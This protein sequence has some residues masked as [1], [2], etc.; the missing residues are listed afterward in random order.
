M[1]SLALAL[2]IPFMTQAAN[3]TAQKI[4]VDGFD[5]L[6]LTDAAHKTEVSIAPAFG[7]NAY[8]MKVNGKNAFWT[9]FGLQELMRNPAFAGNPF[10]ARGPTAWTRTLSTPMGR[11]ICSTRTWRTS[12]GTEIAFPYTASWPTGRSGSWPRSR[13]M[14]SRRAL[15]AAWNSGSTRA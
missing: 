15:P 9:P 6:R 7:N 14:R 3:Y 12:G 2:L 1:K 5:V 4:V 10:L 13:R 8:E 11:S